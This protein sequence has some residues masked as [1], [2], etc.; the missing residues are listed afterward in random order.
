MKAKLVVL[1]LLLC[2]LA[3]ISL[4]ISAANADVKRNAPIDELDTLSDE[5][6]QL[7]KSERYEDAKKILDYFSNQF[8]VVSIKQK[9]FT[10]DELRIVTGAHDEAVEAISNASLNSNERV[11][12][13]TKFRLA[14]DAISSGKQPLWT[15][16]EEPVMATYGEM[17]QAL[18]AGNKRVYEEKM[19][20]F[21][22]LYQIIYPSLKLDVGTEQFQKL[23]A[24]VEFIGTYRLQVFS[25]G[26][27]QEE[28]A[29]LQ[30]ELEDV[31]NQV[32]EDEA[33]PSLW[34][35]IISTGSIIILTLSYVAVRKYIG[36]KGE[37]KRKR[38]SSHK[39]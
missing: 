32:Y 31:F 27:Q 35:V 14:V 30:S 3:P 8:S 12:T 25:N 2:L 1:T 9:T 22:S 10:M 33:D 5:A 19:D 28:I 37:Q 39:L 4:T 17:E 16:M 29:T 20:S 24:L 7:V 38:K 13:V 26:G 21:L 6:L 34:W 23:N 11:N 15:Q 36:E 18:A